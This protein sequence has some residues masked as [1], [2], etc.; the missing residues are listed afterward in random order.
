MKKILNFGL[1]MKI[2]SLQQWLYLYRTVMLSPETTT[3]N[4]AKVTFLGVFRRMDSQSWK[5]LQEA[6]S[7]VHQMVK[8]CYLSISCIF[9]RFSNFIQ[10]HLSND[11][12]EDPCALT[13]TKLQWSVKTNV[14]IPLAPFIPTLFVSWTFVT[15]VLQLITST[16]TDFKIM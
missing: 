4:K 15:G 7:L 10:E 9:I 8:K 16:Y 3:Q 14:S 5:L 6:K 2:S 12:L 1:Q 13:Q 11:M